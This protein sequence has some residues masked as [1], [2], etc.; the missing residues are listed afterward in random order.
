MI[1]ILHRVIANDGRLFG[2]ACDTTRLVNEACR[3]HDVGPTAAAALGRA[4]TGSTLVAALLKDGQYVQ[5]KFEGSGPLGKIITEAGYDGWSRGYVA[6]PRADVP[7]KDGRIDVASGLGRAGFLTVTKDIGMKKKYQG[8]T[9]LYTSEIGEDIAYYLLESE[10]TPSIVGLSV[11]LLPDGTVSAAGGFLV[12]ALPPIE[13]SLIISLESQVKAL[14]PI[15]EFLNNGNSPADIL[16]LLF[17]DIPFHPTA[18]TNLSYQCSCNRDKMEGA[19]MS[20]GSQ[21]LKELLETEEGAEVQCEFCRDQY[22]FN[23]DDLVRM[24]AMIEQNN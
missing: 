14:P 15:T 4:L 16:S 7:L 8:M 19:V 18:S 13:E 9:Q 3:K 2:L 23:K 5:L 10:Q 22:H 21:E 24:I 12:Q 11:H 17:K 1:D 6:N 20:L